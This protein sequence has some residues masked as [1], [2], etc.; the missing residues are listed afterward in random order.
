MEKRLR[1]L[2]G[3][4]RP[5]G[6][7]T[8][9]ALF[10]LVGCL[11]LMMSTASAWAQSG[12]S[13]MATI[14]GTVMDE[15]GGV[16]PGV[17]VTLKS[18]AIQGQQQVTVTGADGT[19]RFSNLFNGVYDVTYSL[20]GFSKVDRPGQQ[21]AAGFSM[22]LDQTLKAGMSETV[23]V[24]AAAPVVDTTTTSATHNLASE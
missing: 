8:I 23:E 19:F 7:L 11:C 10:L 14:H 9:H 2:T 21:L 1:P 4:Q 20:P 16:L 15:T 12:A 22:K 18:P 5:V 6:R 3:S 24:S 17:T 13:V